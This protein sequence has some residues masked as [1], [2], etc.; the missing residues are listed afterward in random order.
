MNLNSRV[1]GKDLTALTAAR[2]IDEERDR[3]DARWGV[4]NHA[5]EWWLAILTEEV[6]ELA[7]AIL[8]THFDNGTDLGGTANIRKEAVQCAAVAMAMIECI[9]R[10]ANASDQARAG[11]PSPEAG[12]SARLTTETPCTTPGCKHV[13]K[14][15]HVL[16]GSKAFSNCPECNAFVDTPFQSA[17]NAEGQPRRE[18]T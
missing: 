18:A 11:S 15:V 2:S 16:Y 17:P 3:Q 9:D 8:E 12:C 10:T 6:G 7:Q 5:P 4:Q 1:N 13:F 14:P